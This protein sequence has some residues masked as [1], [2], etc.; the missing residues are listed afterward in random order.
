MISLTIGFLAGYPAACRWFGFFQKPLAGKIM[1]LAVIWIV[2]SALIWIIMRQVE[3]Q[4]KPF[5][6]GK[7]HRIGYIAAMV[8]SFLV[9]WVFHWQPPAFPSTFQMNITPQ[10]IV[11]LFQAKSGGGAFPLDQFTAAAGWQLT[12]TGWAHT[13][14]PNAALQFYGV[15]NAPLEL[16]FA[17]GPLEGIVVIDIAGSSTILN[18]YS[19]SSDATIYQPFFASP[20]SPTT[21]WKFWVSLLLVAEWLLLALLLFALF[22]HWPAGSTAF[23]FPIVFLLPYVTT[24]AG[25]NVTLGNDFGPFYYVYKTYLLDFLANGRF[26]LWSPSEAAGYPFFSNPLAQTVYPPNLLLALIYWLNQGYT[27]LDHQVYTVLAI[28]WFSIGL[29]LWLRSLKVESRFAVFA[30]LTMALSYKMTELL[31]F[32]NAAHEAAWFPWILL[33][34]TKLFSATNTKTTVRWAAVLFAA[35]VCLFTAGY[36]YYI[37][38]L[39]FLAAPYLI[40]MLIPRLRT[41][42]FGIEKPDWRRFT[43]G[44]FIA[45]LLALLVCAPYLY[46]MGRTI[47]QTAGRAGDDFQHAT[48]YPFDFQDTVESL[49]Y[50]PAARPEGWFYFG[51]L[52]VVLMTLYFAHPQRDVSTDENPVLAQRRTW[53]VKVALLGWLVF[54]SYIS[55]GDRSYLYLLLYKILPEFSALRGWG[56]LSIALLPG[57]ALLLAYSMADFEGRLTSATTK[58][59]RL[60]QLMVWIPLIAVT[61]SALS[62][63]LVILKSGFTDEY[64]KSFFIPRTAFLIQTVANT[65]GRNIQPDPATLSLWFSLAYIVFG[66]MAAVIV[67]LL[68]CKVR[69]RFGSSAHWLLFIGLGLFSAINLWFGGAWLWNNGFS[70]KEDRKPGN[71]QRMFSSALTTPRKNENS[72]LTL[73]PSFSVGSPPKW[74][75]GRYQEFYFRAVGESDARDA[76]LGVTDGR[77]F[78]FSDSI[79]YETI[80]GYLVDANQFEIKPV[81]HEYT[82]DSLLVEVTMPQSGYFSFID[83]WDEDWRAQVDG[84]SVAMEQLFG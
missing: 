16:V 84:K 43:A 63:Q 71:Y 78:Y 3:Y 8:G 46:Q 80:A 62:Y 66:L 59:R 64:W 29:Y 28:C 82:G 42:L 48:M 6:A 68:I 2:L 21:I 69:L 22:M 76:L 31:R 14:E 30:A 61:I 27:K 45:S 17:T 37:Y 41:I 18:L 44:A 12:E 70:L 4:I 1:L 81:V 58:T 72:T 24:I 25:H 57:L 36:P 67:A 54:L 11:H 32:T 5:R 39:P 79:R 10:G 19:P 20:G 23:F 49:V 47:N 74:H 60:T 38:Y 83:N 35:L 52:G 56:R 65:M 53:P 26:P 55:Y 7:N 77:R 75:Y 15:A 40:F 33:G 51:A 73:S 13:S 9:L 50:P 34:L